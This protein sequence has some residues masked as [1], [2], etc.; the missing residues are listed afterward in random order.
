MT[1]R[2]FLLILLAAAAV[3]ACA[4]MPTAVLSTDDLRPSM[5]S[6]GFGSGNRA[7]PPA[8]S[9]IVSTN[10]TEDGSDEGSEPEE[11]TSGGFGSG[12]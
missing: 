7:E 8:D 5:D 6:G 11:N 3:T 2:G 10:V 9:S 1:H 12:N 4:E